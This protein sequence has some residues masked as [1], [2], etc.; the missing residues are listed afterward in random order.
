[1][2]ERGTKMG[3]DQVTG[4]HAT[5]DWSDIARQLEELGG[6]V[7]SYI[8]AKM[9]DPET[10][11]H[12]AEVQ[13]QLERAAGAVGDAMSE[14][15]RSDAGQ[16]AYNAATSVAGAAVAT[17]QKVADEVRPHLAD[18]IRKANEAIR[19]AADS[20]TSRSDSATEAP[21]ADASAAPAPHEGGSEAGTPGNSGQ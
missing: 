12:A 1:M 5:P 13:S 7:A 19:A 21:E 17:G 8:R 4:N 10:K 9:D 20:M 11:R 3:D 16:R 6:S 2:M 18:A 14:A 15:A